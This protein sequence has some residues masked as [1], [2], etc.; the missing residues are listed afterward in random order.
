MP[1]TPT[2]AVMFFKAICIYLYVRC[3][4]GHKIS[5]LESSGR[6]GNN[7]ENVGWRRQIRKQNRYA[8]VYLQETIKLNPVGKLNV[9]SNIVS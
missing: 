4:K 3:F 9:P 7:I 5:I 2:T 6:E 1:Y 8:N